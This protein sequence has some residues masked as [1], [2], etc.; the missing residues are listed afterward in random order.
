MS[1]SIVRE[2]YNKAAENYS[3]DRNQFKNDKYLDKFIE[4]LKQDTV[5]DIGC[6]SGV[7]IDKYLIDR[8][9]KIIGIDISEKQIELAKKKVPEANYEVKDMSELKHE[10]YQVD[11]VVST[12]AVFHTPREEH[13]ELFNKINSFLP[14]GGI[15]LVTMGA[16]EWE[17]TEDDF[18]GAKMWWSHY[19][20]E[21]N[22]E[23]VKNAGFEII[24]D[25]IDTGNNESH[26]I[27]IARKT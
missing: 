15:I 17:G 14:K 27:I 12:Y 5:L 7:P 18:H 24:L 9:F 6:G 8:G 11:G 22:R 20:P 23:I 4:L 10:E 2:G 1:K 26:Q 25:E 16:G 19:G 21:K 3:S 13:Q